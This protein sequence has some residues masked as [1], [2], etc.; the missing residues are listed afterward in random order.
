ME[1]ITNKLSPTLSLT[2]E[3]LVGIN[4][5][6]FEL[7][8][9]I[10]IGCN[11]VR[12]IG[13][14]GIG[15][16][17]KTTIAR[18]NYNRAS[19]LF[20]GSA[21]LANVREVSSKGGLLTLQEQLL[22]EIL[23]AENVRLWNVY[24]G[25]EM[26]KA[27][28]RYKRVLIVIDDVDQLNQLKALAGKNDWFGRGSRII[29]TTRDENLLVRHG[30]DEIY[31]P[32]GLNDDEALQLFSFKA[33]KSNHPPEDYMTLST[34]V[35]EYVNGLPLALEV[36]GSFLFGKTF[37]EWKSALA[38][39]KENPEKQI[40]D[41]FQIG[42]DGLEETEKKIF[43]DVACFFKGND[44]DTTIKIW[45]SCGFYP[46]IGIRVLIDKSLITITDNNRLWMHD[47]LQEMG[48]K[49]VRQ[50]SLGDPGKRSRLWLYKDIY[51]VLI[52]NSVRNP[53][54]DC[55]L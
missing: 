11:G 46:D 9:C 48:W 13:I 19:L 24:E 27:R 43:L 47:L 18:A 22:C 54:R 12:V 38:R 1:F 33:F 49:L 41:T 10:N 32:K 20:E 52:N 35:I 45:D 28:L 2:D 7:S 4:S 37:N 30:V 36:L 42:Y 51:H 31:K 17:G 25:I 23:K 6:L 29:I 8:S 55:F 50:E 5:R 44:K 53:S 39:M 34:M 3:D 16:I 40:L 14:T 15:G 26:I 21:F